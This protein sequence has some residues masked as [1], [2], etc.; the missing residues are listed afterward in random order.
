MTILKHKCVRH[1]KFR[2][3]RRQVEQSMTP[4]PK[5]TYIGTVTVAP[6]ETFAVAFPVDA[7]P[8]VIKTAIEKAEA[9]KVE[10]TAR[11]RKMFM[12]EKAGDDKEPPNTKGRP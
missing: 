5:R 10:E 4:E 12:N 6:G 8:E 1:F 9:E 11:L 2:D 3:G 7:D